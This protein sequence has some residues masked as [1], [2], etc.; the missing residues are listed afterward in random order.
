MQVEDDVEDADDEVV[1]L[2]RDG[3]MSERSLHVEIP[4]VFM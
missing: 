4:L 2:V 3:V 1:K